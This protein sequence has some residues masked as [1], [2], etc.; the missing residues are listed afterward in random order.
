MPAVRGPTAVQVDDM[1]VV[2]LLDSDFIKQL[3]SKFSG[4]KIHHICF[5]VEQEGKRESGHVTISH[6]TPT[7]ETGRIATIT[8]DSAAVLEKLIAAV[9][10]GDTA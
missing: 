2:D 1:K 8:T 7:D 4:V 5:Y 6:E 3:S 10:P 9:V